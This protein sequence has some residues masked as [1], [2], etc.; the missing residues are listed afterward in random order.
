MIEKP[1]L[2]TSDEQ[3][4]LDG[5]ASANHAHCS[6]SAATADQVSNMDGPSTGDWGRLPAAVCHSRRVKDHRSSA[7]SSKASTIGG[8]PVEDMGDWKRA[9]KHSRSPLV[10]IA[11]VVP[12]A[13]LPPIRRDDRTMR[14]QSAVAAVVLGLV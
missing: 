13:G 9:A 7:A 11:R 5:S 10:R 8:H 12:G 14:R 1:G 6:V 2:D 3:A 4:G